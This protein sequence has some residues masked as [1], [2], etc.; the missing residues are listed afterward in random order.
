MRLIVRGDPRPRSYIGIM[1]QETKLYIV[2]HNHRHGLDVTPTYRTE[3]PSADDIIEEL[4]EAGCW[5]VRDEPDDLTYVE[6]RGP[7][8]TSP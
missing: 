4:K 7:F 3:E 1:A 8:P 5:D 6:V 2:V